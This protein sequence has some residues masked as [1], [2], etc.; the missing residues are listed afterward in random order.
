VDAQYKFLFVDIGSQGRCSDSGVYAESDLQEALNSN[1][2]GIPQ[3]CPLP[4]RNEDFPYVIVADDAFPLR[5]NLMKPFPHRHLNA[6][7]RMFNY[8]LS[9]ARRCVENAFGIMSNRFRALLNPIC[10]SPEKVDVLVLACCALHNMLRTLA[11][12]KYV[13]PQGNPD[14]A[15]KPGQL[16]QLATAKVA[17]RRS[18]NKVGKDYRDYLCQYFSSPEGSIHWQPDNL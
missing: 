16:R 6:Q 5:A 2:L 8:R 17:S 7:Q 9:R 18:I 10:L 1:T 11:P 3:P 12:R 13:N 4:G 15:D 14:V